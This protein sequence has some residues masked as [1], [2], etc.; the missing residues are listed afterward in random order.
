MGAAYDLFL[1]V[2]EDGTLMMRLKDLKLLEDV[3]TLTQI[4]FI[5][6]SKLQKV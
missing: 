4:M 6:L 2:F 1:K 3:M 5:L